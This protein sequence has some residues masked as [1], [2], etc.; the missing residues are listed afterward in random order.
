MEKTQSNTDVRR[1]RFVRIVERRVNAILNNLDSLGK[2]SN[3]RNYQYS[4]VDATKVFREI[5]KKTRE[6]KALFNGRGSTKRF[7]LE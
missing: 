7:T 4:E 2:C 5:D 3:K 6:I 1:E